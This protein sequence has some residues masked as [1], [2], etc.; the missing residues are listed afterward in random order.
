VPCRLGDIG[1]AWVEASD[2]GRRIAWPPIEHAE[3]DGQRFWLWLVDQLASGDPK[4]M[5]YRVPVAQWTE[6]APSKRKVAGSN[7]AGGAI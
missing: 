7:P 6:Q 5:R 1:T 2:D 3:R 4:L